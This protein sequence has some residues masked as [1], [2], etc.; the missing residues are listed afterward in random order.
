[1]LTKS[2]VLFSGLLVLSAGIACLGFASELLY[3]SQISHSEQQVQSPSPFTPTS[4][5]IYYDDG[6]FAWLYV[7]QGSQWWCAV[8]M[9]PLVPCTLMGMAWYWSDAGQP[10]AQ[11]CSLYVWD[12]VGG[13]P[14]TVIEGPVPFLGLPDSWV[15]VDLSPPYPVFT[16][17]FFLGAVMMGPPY[18]IFDA[19]TTTLRSWYST[20]GVSWVNEGSGD[21]LCRALV[22]YDDVDIHDVCIRDIDNSQGYFMPNPGDAQ[23][24]AEVRNDGTVQ[25][26]NFDVECTIRDTV[27]SFSIVY[28]DSQTVVSL[29]PDSSVWVAF[30]PN[31]QPSTDG[32]YI[33]SVRSLLPG[34][35][36]SENDQLLRE[37][38]VCTYPSEFTYDDGEWDGALQW[39]AGNGHAMRFVPPLYPGQVTELKLSTQ[40][41]S[42]RY[43]LLDDIGVGG[44][45]GAILVDTTITGADG[46]NAIDI[47]A[48]NVNIADGCFYVAY[49]YV[50]GAVGLRF[51]N[52]PPG[53]DQRWSF[54]GAVWTQDAL[55][56]DW[57]VR[58]TVASAAVHD[59]GVDSINAPPDTVFTGLTYEPIATVKN[60]GAFT[61]TF[62]V[63]CTVDGY[64]DTVSVLNLSPGSAVPCTFSLWTVP[65]TDSTTYLMAC[66]TSVSNDSNPSNDTLSKLIFAYN[67]HDV[68]IDTILSPPD[69][70][71]PGS[72]YAVQVIA[73]NYGEVNEDSCK[74]WCVVDGW[75]DTM[76]VYGLEADSCITLNFSQWMV[77]P[78]GPWTMCCYAELDNDRNGA[79][80]SSCIVIYPH[81]GV[82]ELAELRIPWAFGLSECRPNPFTSST[83]ISYQIPAMD[84]GQRTV[85]TVRVYDLAGRLVRTLIDGARDPGYREAVWDGRDELG[86]PVAG[87]IYFY[88]LSA[89][90]RGGSASGGQACQFRSVKKTV[91]IR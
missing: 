1:M 65:W 4:D 72:T 41:G 30:D 14:G 45:P 82:E 77:P 51:D 12:V 50:D 52:D 16:G 91:L 39:S 74:V 46:W 67:P 87:G 24:V 20:D 81:V 32:E 42:V 15:Q 56:N 80:D 25:E 78:G 79:N 27:Y 66:S 43:Q 8:R 49:I 57:L 64:V 18:G 76:Q 69:T 13:Q 71:W 89:T 2:V 68:G 61:E 60:F 48:Y 59:G 19:A 73:C 17:D 36:N 38:Q 75:V 29:D 9:T 6:G 88:R 90:S 7:H 62:D 23:I 86:T 34:D 28:S 40:A 37:A 63:T 70:V 10:G 53:T 5:T 44:P 47:S 54:E 58:A 11:T 55:G 35:M 26:T 83:T 3:P 21:L 31:W 22:E 84:S 85:V 33:I